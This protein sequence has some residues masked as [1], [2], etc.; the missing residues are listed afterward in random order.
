MNRRNRRRPHKAP[1]YCPKDAVAWCLLHDRG[2][3]PYYMRRKHCIS[4]HI[5]RH[6]RWL[7]D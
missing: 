3:N 6:L 4:K 7:P 5:C 1:G 2:M